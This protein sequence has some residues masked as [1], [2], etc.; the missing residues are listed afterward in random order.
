MLPSALPVPLHFRDLGSYNLAAY[1][2]ARDAPTFRGDILKL[3]R[4]MGL[5]IPVVILA[6]WLMIF[7]TPMHG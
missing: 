4:Y 7:T 3:F 2:G 5:P 6:N 1:F